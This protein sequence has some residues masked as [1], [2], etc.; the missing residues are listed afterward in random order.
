MKRLAKVLPVVPLASL[1]LL[2]VMPASATTPGKNERIAFRR[3]LN[4][5][6]TRAAI[7]A[8]SADGSA[9]SSY[10]ELTIRVTTTR[11]STSG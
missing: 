10:S 9:S 8:S 11:P 5:E 4:D 1:V 7:S 6:H 2:A 3:Y